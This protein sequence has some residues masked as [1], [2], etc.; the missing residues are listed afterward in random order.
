VIDVGEQSA[1]AASVHLASLSLIHQL[2]MQQAQLVTQ[3]VRRRRLR[4]RP[5]VLRLCR[6]AA[7]DPRG[8]KADRRV[9]MTIKQV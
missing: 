4:H 7:L 5:A 8:V 2:G 1:A 3:H 6:A 9:Q